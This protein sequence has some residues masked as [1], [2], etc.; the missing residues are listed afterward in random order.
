M[1]ITPI[2]ASRSDRN[3]LFAGTH[4]ECCVPTAFQGVGQESPDGVVVLNDEHRRN[5]VFDHRGWIITAILDAYG[6]SAH[7]FHRPVTA[8]DR[9]CAQ[10]LVLW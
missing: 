8:C 10:S 9:R 3:G 5:T 2:G 1:R 7:T 6:V 4:A